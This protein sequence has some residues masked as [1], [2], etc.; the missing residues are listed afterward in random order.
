MKSVRYWREFLKM[1]EERHGKKMEVY[2]MSPDGKKYNML[3]T[4]LYEDGK[5][6]LYLKAVQ[7]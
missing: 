5:P 4:I 6:V 7:I 3:Q 2:I 1:A